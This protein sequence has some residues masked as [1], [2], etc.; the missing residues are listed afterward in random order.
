[1]LGGLQ[2]TRALLDEDEGVYGRFER[3]LKEALG[4]RMAKDKGFCSTVWGALA[5]VVWVHAEEKELVTYSFRAAGDLIAAI[6]ERGNYM[7]WYCSAPDG[8]VSEDIAAAMKAR[9]WA[10]R[11]WRSK[12]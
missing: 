5:N 3:D 12:D 6:L 11:P 1:M 9:D 8:M 10:W 2:S 7:E 4:E